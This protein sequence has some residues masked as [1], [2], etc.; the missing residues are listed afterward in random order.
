VVEVCE[1]SH[2]NFL[3]MNVCWCSTWTAY[4]P[5]DLHV[6]SVLKILS[7]NKH[8]PPCHSFSQSCCIIFL[9]VF[10]TKCKTH[11][12]DW[13]RFS[14]SIWGQPF[15]VPKYIYMY[16]VFQERDIDSVCVHL[17]LRTTRKRIREGKFIS[18]WKLTDCC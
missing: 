3:R 4:R 15:V 8:I 6:A 13:K 16:S 18:K 12:L 2:D 10:L 7:E 1:S 17:C 14:V 5:N 9:Y 11:Q